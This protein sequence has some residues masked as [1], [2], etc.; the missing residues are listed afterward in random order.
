[1]GRKIGIAAGALAVAAAPAVRQWV[2]RREAAGLRDDPHRWHVVTVLR[3]PEEVRQRTDT[4][5]AALGDA[6]EVQVRPAPGDRGAELAA[7]FRGDAGGEQVAELRTALRRTRAL[8]E[9]GW[10]VQPD[11]PGTT[12]PT[13]LNAPLRAVTARGQ[14][15]GRL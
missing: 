13:P 4:P 8:L 3:P 11:R 10:A 6:V 2:G 7:R 12:R 9:I 1:M 14:G 15:G 5:L